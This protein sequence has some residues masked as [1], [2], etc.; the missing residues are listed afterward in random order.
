[1]HSKMWDLPASRIERGNLRLA[2][3]T[4]NVAEGLRDNIN[5]D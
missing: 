4:R 2:Y 1:M 3:F 5:R